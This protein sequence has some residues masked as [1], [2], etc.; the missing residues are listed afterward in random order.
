MVLNFLIMFGVACFVGLVVLGHILLAGDFWRH[1]VRTAQT[2]V[3]LQAD[4][5]VPAE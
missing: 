4:S 1:S 5:R 3:D 2:E